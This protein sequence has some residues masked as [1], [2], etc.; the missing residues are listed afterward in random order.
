MW[1]Q[2][3]QSPATISE[4]VVRKLVKSLRFG[5]PH[6]GLRRSILDAVDRSTVCSLKVIL[7]K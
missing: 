3:K 7:V 6:C 5:R 2:V 1:V 4:M